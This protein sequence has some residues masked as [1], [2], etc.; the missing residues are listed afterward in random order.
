MGIGFPHGTI[1]SV[2]CS[3]WLHSKAKF[4]GEMEKELDVAWSLLDD[5]GSDVDFCIE[6][7]L[8]TVCRFS[9]YVGYA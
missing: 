4:S 5:A 8:E 1:R 3:S 9:T 6:S 7:R 2:G